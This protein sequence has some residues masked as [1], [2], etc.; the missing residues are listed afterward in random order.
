MTEGDK[1]TMDANN[2]YTD[3]EDNDNVD[4]SDD[5]SVLM[6]RLVD[7]RINEFTDMR[8]DVNKNETSQQT[9]QHSKFVTHIATNDG[10]NNNNNVNDDSKSG[11]CEDEY[12]NDNKSS[13]SLKNKKMICYSSGHMFFYTLKAKNGVN[14]S[15]PVV[16][17]NEL[18][19]DFYVENRFPSLKA[20]VLKN[21]IKCIPMNAWEE[22]LAKALI[23]M[24]TTRVKEIKKLDIVYL[25]FDFNGYFTDVDLPMVEHIL[26][27]LFYCNFTE[28]SYEF[29]RTFRL[30][31]ANETRDVLKE[32]HSN[33]ANWGDLLQ[34][35]VQFFST[36]FPD[37]QIKIF[38][39]GVSQEM[40]FEGAY[41]RFNSPTST[42][43]SFISFIFIYLTN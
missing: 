37:S 3:D 24:P 26:C 31:D 5:S 15:H 10:N 27:I 41:A 34:Q 33:F 17:R 19:S 11:D 39:H 9:L 36:L 12:S 23:F 6:R 43:T 7:A 21:A 18:F 40:L 42:S 35:T 32:R 30:L 13:I 28:L 20:E 22:T 16:N 38:Y 14:I 1:I 8:S 2:N 4:Y 25:S 29:S